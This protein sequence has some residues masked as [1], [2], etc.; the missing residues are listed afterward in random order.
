MSNH[1]TILGGSTAARVLNCPA[2]VRLS[3]DIPQPPPSIYALE[4]TALHAVME[5]YLDEGQSMVDPDIITCT[6]EGVEITTELYAD[7]LVPAWGAVQEAFKRLDMEWYAVEARVQYTPVEGSFGTCDVVG[8]GRDNLVFLL[9]HKFGHVSVSP[10][11]NKQLMFYAL[12]LMHD[13]DYHDMWT[14]EPSQPVVLGIVQPENGRDSALWTWETTAQELVEFDMKLRQSVVI[15][16][17]D[18]TASPTV[19]DWCKYCR[20]AAVCPAKLRGAKSV[21]ALKQEHLNDLAVAMELA[22]ELEPWIKSVKTLA[23]EQLERGDKI[24]GWKLVA[25]RAMRKWADAT[26]IMTK[27]KNAKK[28][29]VGDYSKQVMFTPPQLEKICKAKGV[30]FKVY[31]SY[32][33]SKSSGTTMAPEDDK[34]PAI[35]VHTESEIPDNM[36]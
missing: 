10:V 14:G 21:N 17:T 24:E 13:P 15:A 11:E 36:K 9:D 35:T 30:D 31:D 3:K 18:E 25:K 7:K 16:T 4:G 23:H 27:L 33:E 34:R 29:K 12:G 1:S 28:L 6:V 19:G 2:S 20:A 8:Q 22:T 32:I 26:D 5:K